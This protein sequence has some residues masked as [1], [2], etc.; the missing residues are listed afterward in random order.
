MEPPI[1]TE[2]LRSGG[3]MTRGVEA[4][5]TKSD[6]L[7]G[8]TL[9]HAGEHGRAAG[10]DDVGEEILA[11]IDVAL[12][13][14]LGDEG[15]IAVAITETDEVGLEERFGAAEALRLDGDDGG[16]GKFEL[17]FDGL[18][19]LLLHL[20]VE[21]EGDVAGLFLDVTDDFLLGGGGR[22]SCRSP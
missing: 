15:G 19:V 22:S 7:L 12:A 9:G 1:Q 6:E 18:V 20:F 10:E 14:G 17:G 4:G 3:A 11:D 16:V 8:E 13:D 2:Y 21:V 5:G